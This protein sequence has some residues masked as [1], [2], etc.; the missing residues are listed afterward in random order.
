M[1]PPGLLK[2][3][4]RAALTTL[5]GGLPSLLA[6]LIWQRLPASLTTRRGLF[7][8]ATHMAV[9][10]TA[11]YGTAATIFL[12]VYFTKPDD[13]KHVVAFSLGFMP[14]MLCWLGGSRASEDLI[15]RAEHMRVWGGAGLVLALVLSG[16]PWVVFGSFALSAKNASYW[17]GIGG[18]L[19]CG[20]IPLWLLHQRL[21]LRFAMSARAQH[22][23]AA[24]LSR[25]HER[26]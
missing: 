6:T 11:W 20:M 4:L 14:L 7:D 1:Y 21:A 10:W 2:S 9:L 8:Q 3:W 5:L 15:R 23:Q 12:A 16:V 17:F 18:G 24:H 26:L 19:L 13:L 25:L 22:S